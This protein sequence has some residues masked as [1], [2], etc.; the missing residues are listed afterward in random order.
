MTSMSFPASHTLSPTSSSEIAARMAMHSQIP[1][2]SATSLACQQGTSVPIVLRRQ[3]YCR[4]H[5]LAIPATSATERG[6]MRQKNG[7]AK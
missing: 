2:I 4:D 6:K 5:P 1:A 7:N 3:L